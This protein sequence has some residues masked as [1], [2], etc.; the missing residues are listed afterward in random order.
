MKIGTAIMVSMFLVAGWLG[1]GGSESSSMP[2]PPVGETP[3]PPSVVPESDEVIAEPPVS[4]EPAPPNKDKLP[5]NWLRYDGGYRI[6]ITAADGDGK[7][8]AAYFNPNPI[9]VSRAE[10][11][12]R[13][14]KWH[15]VVEMRDVGYPGS[16]YSLDYDPEQ[17]VL[18]GTYYQATAG[19]YYEVYFVRGKEEPLSR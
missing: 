12:W 8:Q 9:N 16:F 11:E 19:Q 7:L 10:Y 13:D 4:S 14:E 3:S 1:C 18:Y 6:A 5:G 2:E 17:D 15:I